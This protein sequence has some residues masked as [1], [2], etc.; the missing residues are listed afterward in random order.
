MGDSFLAFREKKCFL[1]DFP[2]AAIFQITIIQ[3][4][5]YMTMAYL[6]AAC[7]ELQQYNLLPCHL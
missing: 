3:N 5:Q 4:N 2:P 7:S 6:G 1:Y